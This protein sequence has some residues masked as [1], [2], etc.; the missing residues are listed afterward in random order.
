MN[1]AGGYEEYASVADLYD[2]VV[3]YRGRPDIDFYLEAA[4]EARGAV[5][6]IGCGTGRVLVLREIWTG[7]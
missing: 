1:S 4:K 2:Y 7:N 5:L 3:P 6:E